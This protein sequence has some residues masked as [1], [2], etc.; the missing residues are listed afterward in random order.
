[1]IYLSI[2]PSEFL[3]ADSSRTASSRYKYEPDVRRV[4]P[5]AAANAEHCQNQNDD[6]GGD[7]RRRRLRSL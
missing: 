6:G 4:D 1:M 3:T 5:V 2:A 7:G